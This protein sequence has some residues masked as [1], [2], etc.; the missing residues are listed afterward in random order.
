MKLNDLVLEN[1]KD[2]NRDLGKAPSPSGGFVTTAQ[3][4]KILGVSMGRVRQMIMDGEL[5]AKSPE[6]G[7]RDNLLS[8]KQVRSMA[9]K[10]RKAGRPE[11]S[12]TQND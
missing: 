11:G 3:A 10:D 7:R 1:E 5:T 2:E 4:A 12:K 8:L 6:K 9:K